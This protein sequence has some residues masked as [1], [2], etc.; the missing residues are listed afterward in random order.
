MSQRG[1]FFSR[2]W[3]KFILPIA[4]FLGLIANFPAKVAWGY[5]EKSLKLPEELSLVSIGG[6]AWNGHSVLSI[7]NK[8]QLLQF[9]VDWQL[10]LPALLSHG[11]FF[12]L[13]LSH[14]GTKLELTATPNWRLTG[15]KGQVSGHIHPLLLNPFLKQ[16]KAWIS[17]TASVNRLGFS[18]VDGKPETLSGAIVWQGGDTYFL[19]P[20]GRSPQL[21][22]YPQLAIRVSTQSQT[23][24]IHA[25]VTRLGDDGALVSGVLNQDGWLS[26]RVNGRLKEAVP[27]LPVPRKPADQALIK[28]KEKVF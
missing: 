15:L 9:K 24:D 3:V 22:R 13:A 20:G 17:G 14:P 26:V 19:P 10:G 16:N 8:D 4:F 6:T 21:I 7:S 11:R 27:D 18:F 28:Y 5:V 25:T 2:K 12:S 1:V 23:G